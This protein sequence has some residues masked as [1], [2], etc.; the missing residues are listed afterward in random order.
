MISVF[1]RPGGKQLW[2]A[3]HIPTF[4]SKAYDYTIFV[5][6]FIVLWLYY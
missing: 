6:Y 2:I 5:L 3:R 4:C 1:Q